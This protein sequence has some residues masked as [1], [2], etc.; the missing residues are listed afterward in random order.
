MKFIKRFLIFLLV[1]G[2]LCALFLAYHLSSNAPVT[3][4]EVIRL[5]EAEQAARAKESF[6]GF[7]E[8]YKTTYATRAAHAK[9]HGCVKA[10]FDVVDT[11]EPELQ[12]GIFSI[13][14]ARYKAWIRLSNGRSSMHNHHDADRDSRGMA[15]K[16]FNIDEVLPHE[17]TKGE[18][19]QDFLMHSN[20]VFVSEDLEDFNQMAVYENKLLYFLSGA[21]PFKWRIRQ[22]GHAIDTIAPPPYSPLW[23]DYHSNLP[24]K[25]GPHNIKFSTHSCSEP[26]IDPSQDK[27]DRNFLRKTLVKELKTEAACFNFKVQLQDASKY[28]PIEDPSIEWKKSDSP[29]ITVANITIPV[30]EFDTPEQQTFCENLSYEPWNALEAH[31]PIGQFNRIRKIVYAAAR[32][33]RHEVN[34][35]SIPTELDW[36]E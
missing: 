20:P 19:I 7:V 6:V 13:P 23:D 30:Q 14:G 4:E 5:D 17:V 35:A 10:Y 1:F 3:T 26:E 8:T 21:N 32:K 15:I 31:R 18:S 33:Y 12:H 27:S 25:L 2:V 11:I 24:F 9:G 36:Q 29:Y 34:N 16:L 28:M 22:L